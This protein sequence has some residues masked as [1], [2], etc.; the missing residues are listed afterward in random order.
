MC[1][2][3]PL[4]RLHCTSVALCHAV[5]GG[6]TSIPQH[7]AAVSES[8][9]GA[10]TQGTVLFFLFKRRPDARFGGQC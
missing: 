2:R 8:L 7:A 9:A 3:G 1:A 5:A 10:D 6:G 4:L